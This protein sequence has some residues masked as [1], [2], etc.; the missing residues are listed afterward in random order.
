MCQLAIQCAIVERRVD[1]LMTRLAQ[2]HAMLGLAAAR[3]GLEVMQRDQPLRHQ[4]A[5]EVAALM[6][7][8]ALHIAS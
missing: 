4:S 2:R 1:L 6:I 8:A 3:F 5:A 7:V